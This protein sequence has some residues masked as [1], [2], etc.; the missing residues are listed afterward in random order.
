MSTTLGQYLRDL[1]KQ[2]AW[3]QVDAAKRI[4]IEQ[5]T[6]SALERNRT[7]LPTMNI[8]HN[9]ADAYGVSEVNLLQASGYIRPTTA[10]KAGEQLSLSQ[11]E[12]TL[13]SDLRRLRELEPL[14]T[15]TITQALQQILT[16]LN[17]LHE[18]AQHD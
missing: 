7:A 14:A 18:K 12:T 6:V 8:L 2:R 11:E 3:S 4:G 10:E 1:R 13:L 16:T 5:T 17:R 15:Y 9:I